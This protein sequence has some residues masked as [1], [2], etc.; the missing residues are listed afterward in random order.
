M[1]FYAVLGIPV[2]ADDETIRS[3]YRLLARRYHPDRGASSSSEQ[4]LRVAE[5][6]E[7]L[8]DP[9]RRRI[10]DLS[11]VPSPPPSRLFQERSEV[12][13]HWTERPGGP[14]RL[15]ED[16]FEE[17]INSFRNDV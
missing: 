9:G 11:L 10:Y 4:F 16:L 1:N 17:F 3:A 12:F 6:Y 5:A 8:I 7:T 2:D 15:L 14:D 13:G